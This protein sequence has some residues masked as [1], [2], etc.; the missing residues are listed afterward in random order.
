MQAVALSETSEVVIGGSDELGK[1]VA[2]SDLAEFLPLCIAEEFVEFAPFLQY[3]FLIL[4][5]FKKFLFFIA[6]YIITFEFGIESANCAVL[7]INLF[8]K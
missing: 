8:L 7:N 2:L 3:F 6:V 5:I 1:D 4:K